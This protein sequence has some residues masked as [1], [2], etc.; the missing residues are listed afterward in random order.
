MAG[1]RG[2]R[3][4][5][6]SPLLVIYIALG[7]CT[8]LVQRPWWQAVV[9]YA[10]LLP[11][12]V[13]AIRWWTR[14]DR[15]L[16]LGID[17]RP[18]SPRAEWLV[19]GFVVAVTVVLSVWFWQHPRIPT[20]ADAPSKI[21]PEA[22]LAAVARNALGITIVMLVPTALLCLVLRLRPREVGLVPRRIGLG[23]ALVV[24]GIAFAVTIQLAT[25][26]LLYPVFTMTAFAL[27]IYLVHTFVNGLPE[28]ILF[29][30]L[31]MS[32]WLALVSSPANAIVLSSL[33]FSALHLPIEMWRRDAV[34]GWRI[35]VEGLSNQPT[36]LVWGYLYY[37]TRSVWPGIVWHT[38]F[39]TLGLLFF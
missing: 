17:I 18:R 32:R 11:G 6:G 38:S 35:V 33:M 10:V 26:Q 30:G 37:R 1:E 20:P 5:Q 25:G 24:F 28:E 2:D 39:T 14:R 27:P 36:G 31:V 9:N 3:A 12:Y 21:D 13:L 22:T 15:P 19:L 4:V 16:T 29:R 8:L 7:F 34:P 23:V